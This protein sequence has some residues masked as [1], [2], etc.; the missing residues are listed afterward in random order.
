MCVGDFCVAFNKQFY[1]ITHFTI[2][3]CTG[4]LRIIYPIPDYVTTISRENVAAVT[5]PETSNDRRMESET[6]PKD[7]VTE[8]LDE[9]STKMSPTQQS[10][11]KDLSDDETSTSIDDEKM[12]GVLMKEKSD[13]PN[14]KQILKASA[15]NILSDD[16]VKK[17]LTDVELDNNLYSETDTRKKNI[18]VTE[19]PIDNAITTNDVLISEQQSKSQSESDSKSI[20]ESKESLK[21]LSKSS[22]SSVKK[23]KHTPTSISEPITLRKEISQPTDLITDS[24]I[25]ESSQVISKKKS[26][27]QVSSK[28][29]VSEITVSLEDEVSSL[30]KTHPSLVSLIPPEEDEEIEMFDTRSSN[31]KLN[32]KL[33]VS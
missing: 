28:K 1:N 27:T 22:A 16:M 13:V 33:T 14:S 10:S 31:A 21:S 29:I 23:A 4:T 25:S 19:I 9:T 32:T 18:H 24:Q 15:V 8:I 12:I 17:E 26:S 2:N 11:K 7:D 30:D 20:N 6:L 5:E 3:S